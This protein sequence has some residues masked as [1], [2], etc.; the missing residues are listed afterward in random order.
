MPQVGICRNCI[1]G[2]N[3]T[4]ALRSI[5]RCKNEVCTNMVCNQCQKEVGIKYAIKGAAMAEGAFRRE[6]ARS[7]GA[8]LI[9][10]VLIQR[11][12]SGQRVLI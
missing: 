4:L 2:I 10:R 6:A 11:V 1:I 8:H 5:Q 9:L 7:E 12:L 3:G